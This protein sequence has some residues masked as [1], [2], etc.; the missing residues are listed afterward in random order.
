MKWDFES[1]DIVIVSAPECRPPQIMCS[2][3]ECISPQ[4]RCDG[5]RD[6]RDG[7]DEVG[8]R[9]SEKCLEN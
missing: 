6:C 1:G 2:S 7:S 4:M 9:K 3:G 8:C 5:R